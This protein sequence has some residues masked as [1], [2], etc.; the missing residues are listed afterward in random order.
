MKWN[1]LLGSLIV[2][3]FLFM[4]LSPTGNEYEFLDKYMWVNMEADGTRTSW[5]NNLMVKFYTNKQIYDVEYND[6]LMIN[7]LFII[8][9]DSTLYMKNTLFFPCDTSEMIVRAR[10]YNENEMIIE[11]LND[12]I[13][14]KRKIPYQY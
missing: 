8:G 2:L 11:S 5:D 14:L 9:K 10:L 12:Q 7:N 6:S 13:Y 4:L 3:M 1:I